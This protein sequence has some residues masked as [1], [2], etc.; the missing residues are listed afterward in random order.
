MPSKFCLQIYCDLTAWFC[1][2]LYLPYPLN[3]G[4][5]YEIGMSKYDTDLYE[6]RAL[7]CTTIRRYYWSIV[8]G[9]NAIS[10][11]TPGTHKPKPVEK[12]T[13]H[14]IKEREIG[15]RKSVQ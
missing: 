14:S 9:N 6:N 13:R 2:R 4:Q 8:P 7:G 15:S 3:E 5:R 1:C 11:G 12:L 10:D